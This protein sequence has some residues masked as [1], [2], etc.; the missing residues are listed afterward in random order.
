MTGTE[1]SGIEAK[2]GDSG[3]NQKENKVPRSQLQVMAE[4]CGTG[5]TVIKGSEKK[6][7]LPFSTFEVEG[8]EG[9]RKG[10]L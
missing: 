5:C 7:V 6:S 3:K 9:G 4:R 1:G 2:T 8:R 10:N